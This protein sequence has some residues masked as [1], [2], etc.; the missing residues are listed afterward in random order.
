MELLVAK[1]GTVEKTVYDCDA[2]VP[3]LNKEVGG[4]ESSHGEL[5]FVQVGG[6]RKLFGEGGVGVEKLAIANG[7]IGGVQICRG[8]KF[9]GPLYLCNNRSFVT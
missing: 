8:E 7:A 3:G 5:E 2:M 9:D 4:D 6:V 1:P